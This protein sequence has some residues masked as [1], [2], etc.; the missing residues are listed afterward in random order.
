MTCNYRSLVALAM[1]LAIHSSALAQTGVVGGLIG[2]A[3]GK[4]LGKA[5]G[6]SDEDWDS[7]LAKEAQKLNLQLPKMIDPETRLDKVIAAPNKNVTYQHTMVNYAE[8]EIDLA[9]FYSVYK[10]DLMS[11]VCANEGM[12]P[13]IAAGVQVAYVYKTK[14]AK[15]IGTIRV[16]AAECKGA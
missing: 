7:A 5:V 4:V 14:D 15:H 10:R 11:R 1:F 9:Y 12:K 3:V 6:K 8:G 13:M 2:G 16:N